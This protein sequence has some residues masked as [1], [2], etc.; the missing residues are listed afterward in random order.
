[1]RVPPEVEE[2]NVLFLMIGPPNVPP[3]WFWRRLGLTVPERLAK[4]FVVPNLSLRINSK[5]LPCRSLEPNLMETSTFGPMRNP[6][7][8][9]RLFVTTLNWPTASMEGFDARGSNPKGPPPAREPLSTPSIMRLFWQSRIP[10][11]TKP[12]SPRPGLVPEPTVAPGRMPTE[13]CAN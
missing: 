4:K 13:S 10:M 11:P 12:A 6:Y 3:N 2:R 8:A 9:D 5:R 7:S 1:M